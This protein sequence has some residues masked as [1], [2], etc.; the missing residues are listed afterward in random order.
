MSK[1]PLP[2]HEVVRYWG[3]GILVVGLTLGALIYV[4]ASRDR[5]L[6]LAAEIAGGRMY[7][8]NLELMGGK[9]GVVLA[10]LND[11]FAS[12]WHGRRLAYTVAFISIATAA[13]CFW[14]ARMM[15]FEPPASN[16]RNED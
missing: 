4:F 5:D 13:G 3:W 9:L 10:D 14:V 2:R 16:A 7:Q 15:S 6:E 12:L 1:E 8:H 11:W